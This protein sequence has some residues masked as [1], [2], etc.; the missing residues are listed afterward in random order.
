[1]LK[2]SVRSYKSYPEVRRYNRLWRRVAAPLERLSSR[3]HRHTTSLSGYLFLQIDGVEGRSR[4]SDRKFSSAV[5][6]LAV[7]VTAASAAAPSP[8]PARMSVVTGKD[9]GGTIYKKVGLPNRKY[10]WDMCLNEA[11]CSGVRWGVVAGDVAGLCLLMTGPLSFKD[12]VEPRTGDGKAIHVTG[13]RKEPEPG[14]APD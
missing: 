2:E 6:L 4:V 10:C 14:G 11:R 9:V 13:A 5:L 7:F 3:R 1:M 8:Q 12:L